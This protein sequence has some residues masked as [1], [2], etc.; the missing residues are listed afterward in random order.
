LA[1]NLVGNTGKVYSFEPEP[2]NFSY[3]KKN[4][5]INN[6]DYVEA[7]NKA[8]SNKNGKTSLFVCSYDTGHHTIN[9]YN[10]IES[11]S[12]G[13]HTEKKSIEIDTVTLDSFLANKTRVDALKMDVE[14]A[15]MLALKGMDRIIKANPNI[16]MFIEFFPL[17]IEKMGDSPREF[18]RKILEDYK[19][20]IFAIPDDYNA[21]NVQLKKL[22]SIDEVMSFRKKEEDHINLFVKR[23]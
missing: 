19:F 21:S 16:K 18:I 9:Q 10:G 20:S 14:G 7:F 17:L 22:N 4:V 13:R 5:E 23:S 1:A 8:V 6:Y 11:Y 3:L 15:E 2:K 12:R